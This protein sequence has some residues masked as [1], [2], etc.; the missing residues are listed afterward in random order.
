[1]KKETGMPKSKQK[2]TRR[3]ARPKA[4]D[5]GSKKL[6]NVDLNAWVQWVLQQENITAQEMLKTEFQWIS[7]ETDIL[8]RCESPNHGEFLALNELQLR[9]HPRMPRRLNAYTSLAEEHFNMPVY[10][11]VINILPHA[12]NTEVVDYYESHFMGLHARRE[13]RVINL[14]EVE[15]TVAFAPALRALLPFVPVMRGGARSRWSPVRRR[16]CGPMK[17]YGITNHCWHS[18]PVLSW[19][20][21]WYRRL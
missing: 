11:V 16:R 7:R 5:I 20:V 21:R 2:K 8:I 6:I 1:M 3:K 17:S 9:P 18:S 19:A 12:P 13:Y 15:A 14:W 10:P 4:A